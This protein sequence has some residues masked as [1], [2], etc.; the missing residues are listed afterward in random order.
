MTGPLVLRFERMFPVPPSRVWRALTDPVELAEWWG[1]RGF[2]NVVEVWESRVGGRY[3]ITMHPPD[4]EAFHLRGEF[5]EVVPDARLSYTFVWEE[6]DPDDIPA[7]VH[8][9]LA[10]VD[11]STRLTIEHGPFQSE[12]R[13]APPTG[14]W[15]E[16]LD[17]LE[18]LL[19]IELRSRDDDRLRE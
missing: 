18:A 9:E 1:P 11:G 6:P 15:T 17:K 4:G 8:V 16:G 12:A 13:M 2:T 5:L 14:G 7:E 19:A 3:R 10:T